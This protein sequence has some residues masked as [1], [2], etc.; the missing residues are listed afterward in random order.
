M[1]RA[2]FSGEDRGT[3]SIERGARGPIQHLAL[4]I[5][6]M[7]DWD[8]WLFCCLVVVSDTCVGWRFSQQR[9]LVWLEFFYFF[10]VCVLIDFVDV[11]YSF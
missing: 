4:G 11:F 10:F 6:L 7:L 2:T 9:L 1:V 8:F 5:D 3:E